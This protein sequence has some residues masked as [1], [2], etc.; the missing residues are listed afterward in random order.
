MD[1]TIADGAEDAPRRIWFQLTGNPP[2]CFD[3]VHSSERRNVEAV[4]TQLRPLGSERTNL[5]PG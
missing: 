3:E 5:L 4:R 2:L 1:L